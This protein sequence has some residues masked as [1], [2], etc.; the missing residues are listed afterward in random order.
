MIGR[1]LPQ[2]QISSSWTLTPD[3]SPQLSPTFSDCDAGDEDETMMSGENYMPTRP[4]SVAIPSATFSPTRPLLSDVLSNN[5][6]PPYTLTAFMA[7][8]SQ[9]HCLE[10]LEFTMEAKR[11]RDNYDTTALHMAGM[12]ITSDCPEGQDLQ[13]AWK[14]LID[15]YLTPGA[16]REIN[17]PGEVR[18]DILEFPH[19]VRPP[20]PE[21][22]DNAV[23][24]MYDLMEESIFLPFLNSFT[25]F[26]SAQSY[27]PPYQNP[28]DELGF[29]NVSLDDRRSYDRRSFDRRVSRRRRSPP[30]TSGDFSNSRSPPPAAGGR[31]SHSNLSASLVP[32]L[33]LHRPGNRLS[34]QATQLSSASM[35]YALTDDSGS[36]S[37]PGREPMTPPTTPPSSDL[38]LGI[39]SSKSRSDSGTWRKMGMKLGW[40][41]KRSAN[42]LAEG[43]P[44][45]ATEEEL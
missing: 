41:R 38:S 40:S 10:T 33:S 36:A 8:L 27:N 30:T 9:N 2:V 37:S 14:R 28:D 7:F 20:P 23:Q 42:T 44:F 29:S 39:T 3:P 26:S 6:P 4:L 43:R 31:H 16:P 32:T 22:L 1:K 15:V 24:R 12:P 13:E 34:T 45:P 17:L 11:Y 21:T 19:A 25:T 18:D 35:D 5:A